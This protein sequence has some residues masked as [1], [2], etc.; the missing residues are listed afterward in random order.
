MNMAKKQTPATDKTSPETIPLEWKTVQRTVSELQ[1]FDKN[2]RTLTPHRRK[3]LLKSLKK[4]NLADTPVINTDNTV[5]SGNKRLELLH[6]LGR[7]NETI[8]VRIPN[9]LL[10]EDEVKQLNVMFNTHNGEWDWNIFQKH[11]K[12]IDTDLIP[13]DIPD[14]DSEDE[15]FKKEFNK[16]NDTN[17]VYPIVP[18]FLEKYEAFIFIAKNEIDA[19]WIREKFNM[20]KMK[21][22][23]RALYSRSNI[24]DIEELKNVL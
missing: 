5:I 3:Q 21:S 15:Q 6:T 23:K 18:R 8:D 2:P 16:Y 24:I 17:A 1:N 22:Y 10:T 14:F 19:N 7:S 20:Q 9:R 12:E 13:I 4:Y 11:F